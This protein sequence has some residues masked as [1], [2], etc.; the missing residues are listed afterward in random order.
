MRRDPAK[1]LSSVPVW[2]PHGPGRAIFHVDGDAFFAS[3]EVAQNPALRGKPVVTGSERGIASSMTY[4]AKRMGVKRAMTIPEIKRVCPEAVILPSDYETY[5][6]FSRRMNS[7]IGRFTS[8]VE[9]YSIDESFADLT[10]LR[11]T[12]RMS[13]PKIA[14]TIKETLERELGL[15]FSAGLGASKV[16][17]KLASCRN[18]PS[19]M[20]VI[21]GKNLDQ[22]LRETL[23]GKVWGIGP[24]TS[25][26][27]NK[28]G[29]ETA[30]DFVKKEDRWIKDKLNKPAYELW[31]ELSGISI[32]KVRTGQKHDYQSISKTKTFTPPSNDKEF[33]FAQLSKNIENACIKA[34]RH[35]LLALE[36]VVYLKRQDFRYRGARITLSAETASASD[37]VPLARDQFENL[38]KE[39]VLYRATG[40]VLSKLASSHAR[41]QDLF[42]SSLRIKNVEQVYKELDNIADKYGKHTVFLASSLKAM[43]GRQHKG[44]RE[45][46]SL[47]QTEERMFKGETKRKRIGLPM[48]GNV[49]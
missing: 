42:G 30:L 39:G 20:T 22:Y 19:G 6:L 9:E 7:I 43:K 16:I 21:G 14:I 36:V 26:Y 31:Q 41:Q 3:C 13:Y 2:R 35:E 49:K 15:T 38:Y 48:L 10:G 17:A 46:A 33:V 23:V 32:Y 44:D 37:L 24:N 47:R 34:R 1:H 12:L 4:E 25:A 8:E 45:K 11:R 18:K 5:S 29:I 40:V 27:L 28:L